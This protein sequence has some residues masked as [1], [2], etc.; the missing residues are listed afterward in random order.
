M[1]KGA[2]CSTPW[3]C[4]LAEIL[5]AVCIHFFAQVLE[6]ERNYQLGF[7]QGKQQGPCS[8]EQLHYWMD[9]LGGDVDHKEEYEDFKKVSAWQVGRRL[10]LQCS[11]A[12]C[13]VSAPVHTYLGL[14]RLSSMHLE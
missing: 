2:Y 1:P 3:Q 8:L 9:L 5:H 12:V 11:F 7:V 10:A 14:L 13:H 6:G 4:C